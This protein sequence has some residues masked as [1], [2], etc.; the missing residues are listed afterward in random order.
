MF[1]LNNMQIYFLRW[2]QTV[3]RYW[4]QAD[5]IIEKNISSKRTDGHRGNF[6]KDNFQRKQSYKVRLGMFDVFM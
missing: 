3:K 4:K 2:L 5:N 6:H 1:C